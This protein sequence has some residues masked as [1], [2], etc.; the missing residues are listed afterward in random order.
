VRSG[1]LIAPFWVLTLMGVVVWLPMYSLV[2]GN[3]FGDDDDDDEEDSDTE[4][5]TELPDEGTRPP[6]DPV[7]PSATNSTHQSTRVDPSESEDD[8]GPLLGRQTSRGSQLLSRYGSFASSSVFT[9]DEDEPEEGPSWQRSSSQLP[10]S[11]ISRSG[12]QSAAGVLPVRRR[13]SSAAIGTGPG[14]RRMSSNL[15]ASLSG[16]GYGDRIGG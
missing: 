8:L 15:G 13:R 16:F 5:E 14:F 11:Q 1:Y 6:L 12:S 4:A 9:T 3:G 10:S 2:E 7:F